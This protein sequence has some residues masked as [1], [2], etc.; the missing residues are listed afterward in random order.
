MTRYIPVLFTL[1]LVFAGGCAT[2]EPVKTAETPEQKAFALHG[3]YVIYKEI[4]ADLA[5]DPETPTTV[6]LA[7]ERMV[8]VGD[9]AAV[10]LREAAAQLELAR[11]QL[12]QAEN[13]SALDEFQ[14]AL[15]TF[16]SRWAD[17]QPKLQGFID[18]V[19]EAI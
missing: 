15:T 1:L 11:I 7:F 12:G 4:A 14:A 6:V 19:K 5:E 10:L 2:L 3:T 17:A 8:N 18:A 9:P 13:Q 16:N